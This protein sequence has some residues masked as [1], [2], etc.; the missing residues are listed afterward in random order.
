MR[1]SGTPRFLVAPAAFLALSAAAQAPS[2][3]PAVRVLAG[4]VTDKRV[5]A[6]ARR[7]QLTV[8]LKVRGD[9]LDGV[10]A[11]RLHLT[12]ARD[13]L[14]T[15]LLPDTTATPKF[16]DVRGERADENL[17]L[18]NPPREAKSFSLS[19]RVELF[20]PARDP[21][22]VVKV[23]KALLN[24]GRALASPGLEAAKMRFSVLRRD[25]AVNESV[26]LRGRTADFDRLHSIGILGPD[27]SEVRVVGTGRISDG[28]EAAMTL[29]ASGP[30]PKDASLVFTI[31]TPKALVPVPFDMKDVPLP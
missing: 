14:G 25:P 2:A 8:Q 4:D 22:S 28:E 7:G 11:L 30:I 15:P 26:T 18:R 29:E 21:G 24:S 23:P 20:V 6:T 1:K 5:A 17:S 31:L 19:G 16:R 27:G 12:A 9:G 13:D 3:P 10:R